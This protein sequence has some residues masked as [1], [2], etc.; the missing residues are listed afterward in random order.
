[1]HTGEEHRFGAH[2]AVGVPVIDFDRFEVVAYFRGDSWNSIGEYGESIQP[3]PDQVLIRYDSMS[4]Q[5]AGPDGGGVKVKPFGIWVIDRSDRSIAME[6]NVQSLI[7]Q[8]PIWK[9]QHRFESA[10]K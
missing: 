8:P 10:A 3:G 6:E 5:T 1:M 2:G 9:E 4:Y 7:G